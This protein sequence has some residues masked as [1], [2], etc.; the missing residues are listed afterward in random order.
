LSIFAPDGHTF[1][2]DFTWT[3]GQ[4]PLR[5]AN[6]QLTDIRTLPWVFKQLAAFEMI[7]VSDVARLEK[8]AAIEKMRWTNFGIQSLLLIPIIRNNNLLGVLGLHTETKKANWTQEDIVS[9]QLMAN[10]FSSFWSRHTAEKDQIEKLLFVEGLLDATPAPIFYIN[11]Q[12]EYRGC[13]KA[14]CH[15][16][17]IEKERL[18]GKTAYDFNSKERAD[19]LLSKDFY[20]MN[21][22]ETATYEESAIYADGSQHFLI[23]HKAPFFDAEGNTAGLIAVMADVTAQKNLERTLEEERKSLAQKVEQQTRELREA[24]IE[25]AQAAKAKDEFLAAMSHELRTPLNAILGLSEAL[26][27][28]IYGPINPRQENTISRIQESGSHLLALVSDILDLAKIGAGRM[29]LD[30]A[31]VDAAFICES[32]ISMLRELAQGKTLSLDLIMDPQ[33]KIIYADGRRLKQILLNLLSNAIKFTPPGGH[34]SLKMQGDLQNNLVHFHIRDTGIGISQED[35]TTIFTPFQQIDSSLSRKFEGAGLGLALAAQMTKLHNGKITAE[36]TPQKGSHFCV[37]LPWSPAEILP[38]H[39]H[40]DHHS[41]ESFSSHQRTISPHPLVLIAEDDPATLETL[42]DY[43]K[44]KKYRVT[45]AANGF[46][47]YEEVKHTP[48]DIILMDIQMPVMDGLETIRRIR[49]EPMAAH[50]PII[51]ITALAMPGDKEKCL[52]A[53]ANAYLVKPVQLANLAETI[54]LNLNPD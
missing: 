33:I 50:I 44:A 15:F 30:L 7:Y 48:P 37:S 46:L 45:T 12:G 18:I 13:N 24:N 49:N 42:T 16:Y 20:L 11:Q 8:D 22:K 4:V 3:N 40:N 14:F 38:S 51:A 9:L 53:G 28:Q 27:E 43:L 29:E 26:Q 19:D 47:A 6:G 39:P 52:A 41:H 34:V 31:P 32:T 5:K 36:S 54:Q 25:L 35:L 2:R 23:V 17:G 21:K 1:N 10:I